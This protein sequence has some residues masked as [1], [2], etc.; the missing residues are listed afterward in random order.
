MP[1]L[2]RLFR[3]LSAARAARVVMVALCAVVLSGCASTSLT[4]MFEEEEAAKEDK[5]A[6][7]IYAEGD[8]LLDEADWKE[9]AAKFEEVDKNYPYSPEARRA[10]V[11]SAYA[12]YKQGDLPKA[13][14][15]ARRY[16]TLH[17]G[18]DEAPLAQHI[19]ASAYFDRMNGPDRDQSDTEKALNELEIL[20]RRYPD[21]RYAPQARKRIKIARDLLAAKE[22]QV[23][24]YYLE[25]G[26]YIAAINRFRTVVE[27]YQQT[28]HVEEA[29][30]RLTEAYMALGIKSEAQTAAAVLGHNYPE[31]E[32]YEDAYALLQSD[33][34]EPREDAGSWISRQWTKL[35]QA[36]PL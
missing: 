26:N 3:T 18:T 22:M 1:G 36:S 7:Q 29:L 12:N 30:S 34:L 11:M 25:R 14:S 27:K 15:A 31:S 4:G 13:V 23:G 19:I 32:W 8:A 20:V 21:S 2:D 5:T 35:Q 24:R 10:I 16:L 33:G 17:P 6:A 28:K 9:A